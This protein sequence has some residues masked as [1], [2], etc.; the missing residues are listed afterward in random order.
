MSLF[1][2][3]FR[4][5]A[6]RGGSGRESERRLSDRARHRLSPRSR[7]SRPEPASG[8]DSQGREN[9]GCSKHRSLRKTAHQSLFM[10]SFPTLSPSG[11]GSGREPGRRLS[12]RA[13]HRLS[14]SLLLRPGANLCS[15][16]AAGRHYEAGKG[17]STARLTV[18]PVTR[19]SRLGP[20]PF[21]TPLQTAHSALPDQAQSVISHSTPFQSAPKA[22]SPTPARHTPQPAPT[23]SALRTPSRRA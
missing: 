5:V 1:K 12:D 21:P 3:S 22:P 18:R 17:V 10:P 2:P 4:A 23:T 8:D 7:T 13:R 9:C 20:T 19:A 6:K 11:C 14:S 15:R 16:H